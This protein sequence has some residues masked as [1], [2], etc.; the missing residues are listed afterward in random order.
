[1]S[2]RAGDV[3]LVLFGVG[4]TLFLM[5]WVGYAADRQGATPTATPTVTVT[6]PPATV[7]VTLPASPPRTVVVTRASRSEPRRV[8]G[9]ARLDLRN[10]R[11]WDEIARCESGRDWDANRGL[12]DGGLQFLPSTWR[13]HR[14]TDFAPTANRATRAEQIT[15]ANRAS[16]G[17]AWLKPWPVCGKRAAAKFGMRFP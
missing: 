11:L 13:A 1:M 8:A 15:I 9:T 6:A 10:A 14:G 7:R 4:V 12:Y 3:A 17:G 2:R 16:S 5:M